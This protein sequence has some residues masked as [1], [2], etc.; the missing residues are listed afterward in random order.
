MWSFGVDQRWHCGCVFFCFQQVSFVV[1]LDQLGVSSSG[2]MVSIRFDALTRD[3]WFA[4]PVIESWCSLNAE[5]K[6]TTMHQS[7]APVGLL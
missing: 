5:L 4:Q 2:E 1:P 3:E 7:D 6:A